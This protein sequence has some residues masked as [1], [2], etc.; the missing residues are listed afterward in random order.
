[1][2]TASPCDEHSRAPSGLVS[3]EER[4][5]KLDSTVNTFCW[6]SGACVPPTV[7]SITRQKTSTYKID[8]RPFLL[9][10][11]KC[12]LQVKLVQNSDYLFHDNPASIASTVI[13]SR[14]SPFCDTSPLQTGD[15]A[16][17]FCLTNLPLGRLN[18]S[19]NLAFFTS[20]SIPAARSWAS[21]YGAN[22]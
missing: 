17:S 10:R 6:C 16:H 18:F 20:P 11:H 1:M 12:V 15:S 2:F 22:R 21:T 19:T 3:V 8:I 4:R 14:Q 9:C 13:Q 5:S 7:S